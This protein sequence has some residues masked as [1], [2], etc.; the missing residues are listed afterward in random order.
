MSAK[1]ADKSI[2]LTAA[3]VEALK[4]LLVEQAQRMDDDGNDGAFD[5][6]PLKAIYTKVKAVQ[7]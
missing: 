7:S 5:R 3:E 2:S 6:S 4:W 1:I